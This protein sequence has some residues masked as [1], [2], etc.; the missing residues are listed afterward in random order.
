MLAVMSLATSMLSGLGCAL[1]AGGVPPCD[2]TTQ[3][4][5]A[6]PFCEVTQAPAALHVRC[7]ND[8][9]HWVG[10]QTACDGEWFED[11]EGSAVKWTPEGGLQQLP[12]PPDTLVSDARAVNNHGTVVGIRIGIT[13]GVFHDAWA[14]IWLGEKFVE[15]PP[16]PGGKWAFATAVNNSD[17]VVGGRLATEPGLTRMAFVWKDGVITDIDPRPFGRDSANAGAISDSGYVV[18]SLGF[19]S[20]PQGRGFRWKDGKTQMLLPLPGAINCYASCV[21]DS[22]V[23]TGACIFNMGTPSSYVIPTRWDLNGV[24]EALPLLDGFTSGNCRAVN[25]DGVV[26]G[27]VQTSQGVSFQRRWVVWIDGVPHP[28]DELGANAEQLNE[29]IDM[30]H[31]GQIVGSGTFG[32]NAPGSAWILTP[33]DSAADL[34]HD[35]AVDGADL[36]MLLGEWGA[37]AAAAA[38]F[39][40]DG[41][42][43]GADLG[44][45][46]GE[47]T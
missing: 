9:G 22:G 11:W 18:G 45:L 14:C 31:V 27:F 21:D 32:G 29:V 17:C 2:Y 12:V 41:I 30:N 5:G 10:S 23:A 16:L 15:I 3:F 4:A 25:G 28:L 20:D 34:N 19:T 24:P 39:N 38:D 26:L 36:G 8:L 1:I 42:V 37:N 44:F 43:D 13:E 40:G 46:L 6:P 33:T 47:W 7:I 35:C